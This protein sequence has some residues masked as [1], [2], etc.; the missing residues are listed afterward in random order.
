MLADLQLWRG[1]FAAKRAPV[2]IEGLTQGGA[3]VRCFSLD[4]AGSC[5]SRSG[6]T[7]ATPAA[8]WQRCHTDEIVG[9][10]SQVFLT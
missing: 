6:R 7:A 4:R 10:G 1:A 5:A 9:V 2:H 3:V 8:G